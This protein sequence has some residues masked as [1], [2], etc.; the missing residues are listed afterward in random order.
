M[1]SPALTGATG[2]LVAWL[3]LVGAYIALAYSSRAISGDPP[4]DV[5]Y[6]YDTAAAGVAWYAISLVLVLLITRGPAQRDLLALRRPRSIGRAVALSV[7]VLVGI[8]AV[9]VAL[10]PFLNAGKEQGLAPSGW[11]PER[12]GA[13]AANFVVIAVIAPVVEELMFRGAGYSL[14]ARFGEPA[15]VL[16]VGLLFGLVHGLIAGLV[17]LSIFGATLAW[18]RA[19]TNSVYPGIAVHSMFNAIAL[20]VAVTA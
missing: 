10:E 7:A 2:R 1:S 17:V 4:G 8:Y 12:A 13:Y 20:V 6:R 14:L 11:E 9:T 19:R 5:L 18:L 16:L 15:A 3:G